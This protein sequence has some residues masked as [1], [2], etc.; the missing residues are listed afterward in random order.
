VRYQS[1]LSLE[2]IDVPPSTEWQPPSN[3][4]SFFQIDSGQGYWLGQGEPR[5]LSAGEVLVL[6]PTATGSLRASQL[7]PIRLYHFRFCPE[8]LSGFLSLAERQQLDRAVTKGAGSRGLRLYPA[9]HELAPRFEELRRSLEATRGF[10]GRCRVL[11][12]VGLVL[13]RELTLSQR[14]EASI[15]SATK[16]IRILLEHLT[17]EEFLS[18]SAQDLAAYC[19]CSLRHFS[20]L[21]LEHFGVSLRSRQTEVRLLRARRLLLE[22]DSRVMTVA[23][24]CGYRHLG[25]FNA[26][27]KKRFG[28]TPTE[29]RKEGLK[30]GSLPVGCT[31]STVPRTKPDRVT[32]AANAKPVAEKQPRQHSSSSNLPGRP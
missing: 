18:A 12:F 5:Q 24:S 27:F 22:T 4:W 9:T 15:L 6:P 21:F 20:R 13:E 2:E 32:P 1:H 16:R 7:T 19:G 30:N 8:M 28:M 10:S 14:P 23:A 3:C 17:E 26:L 11:Q 29:W 31:P 25:V